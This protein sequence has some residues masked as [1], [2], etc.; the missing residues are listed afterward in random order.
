MASDLNLCNLRRF[1]LVT[2]QREVGMRKRR[3]AI[4]FT[5]LLLALGFPGLAMAQEEGGEPEKPGDKGKVEEP[6]APPPDDTTAPSDQDLKTSAADVAPTTPVL[7]TGT[8]VKAEKTW[9]DIVCV[10]RKGIIKKGRVALMPFFGATLN[11]NLIQ[12]FTLGGEVTYF[13]TDILSLGVQGM[14]FIKNVLDQEFFTRYHFGRIPSLNKY[15]YSITL[16]FSYVPIYGK[17]A[18]FNDAIIHFEVFVTAGVGGTGTEI[19]PR[20]YSYEVFS[21]PF[22]LT[23]PIG[24]GARAFVTKW[25]A[26]E[27]AFK[28]YMMLDKFEPTGRTADETIDAVKKR[29]PTRF[30]NNMM[31]NLGVSFFLPTDFKY[32]TF[33]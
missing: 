5:L 30:I 15:K 3:T 13:L 24:A 29:G 17:F 31:F 27:I 2:R 33:R 8:R 18:L 19:V 14:G 26:I 7:T 28:D 20:D 25:L 11:D 21:N 6:T 1:L 9:K 32:T 12:H 22:S 23:F 16:N 4:C 10:P